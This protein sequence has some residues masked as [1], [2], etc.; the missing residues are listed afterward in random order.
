[1]DAEPVPVAMKDLLRRL[2]ELLAGSEPVLSR[3]KVREYLKQDPAAGALITVIAELARAM[4]EGSELVRALPRATVRSLA[5]PIETA[6]R[7]FKKELVDLLFDIGLAEFEQ[8]TNGMGMSFPSP[9]TGRALF[10]R[11]ASRKRVV[12]S[13]AD[14]LEIDLESCLSASG[15]SSSDLGGFFSSEQA[16]LSRVTRLM[17]ACDTLIPGLDGVQFFTVLTPELVGQPGR[18]SSWLDYVRSAST[19]YCKHAGLLQAAHSYS[20]DGEYQMARRLDELA[21][22]HHPTSVMAPYLSALHAALAGDVS[23][24]QSRLADWLHSLGALPGAESLP[25]RLFHE[26]RAL[27]SKVRVRDRT[28]FDRAVSHLPEDLAGRIQETLA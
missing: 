16:S 13:V 7:Y 22:R 15:F 10:P 26:D 21:L 23:V 8:V 1:M 19:P 2:P 14:A 17:G 11:G 5:K 24:L 20:A 28:A 25:A 27:W 4:S 18:S 6:R 9:N 3:P 12:L